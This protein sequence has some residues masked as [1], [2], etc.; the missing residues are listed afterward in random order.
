MNNKIS[1]LAIVIISLMVSSCSHEEKEVF[2]D[3][4]PAIN[5]KVSQVL[6]N[7][8][9]PFLSVSGKI[10]ASNSSDLSTRIM[11]YV[12]KVNV[13]VG[14]KVNKGQLLVSINNVDLQAKRAQVNA[15]ITEAK[16]ALL[17]AKKDYERFNNLYAKNSA[18]QKE[19]DDMTAN[20]EMAKARVEG[21]NQMMNEINAQFK[22]SNITAPFNGIITA[23]NI[24][25][26]DMANPGVPLI[27]IETPGDLEVVAMVPETEISQIKKGTKVE[28]LVKSID[29]TVEGKVIEVSPSAKYTGGQ[30]LVKINIDKS[31]DKLLSGMFTT[32]QF[33][34]T[35][36]VKTEMVLIPQE[37]IIKYGELSGIYTVSQSNTALLRWLRLGRTY[38]NQVEVLAGL[39][40]DEAFITEAEGKLFNGAKISIQ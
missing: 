8:K 20:F 31:D 9:S 4:T 24:E 16:A 1:I 35:S 10:Q 29:T 15:S 12:D 37:S 18:T 40:A 5:V 30:Y 17:N 11:G 7:D 14:D 23:K 27:S 21:A 33:P 39:Q 32:V 19:L 34:I 38:G 3:N 28:V 2:V 36:K 6:A 25:V 13:N 22:Y 26:G